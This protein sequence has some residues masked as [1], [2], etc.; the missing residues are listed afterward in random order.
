MIIIHMNDIFQY[1][2]DL[3]MLKIKPR[4]YWYFQFFSIWKSI[5]LD[6]DKYAL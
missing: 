6:I 3:F 5:A 1:I 4:N 2:K